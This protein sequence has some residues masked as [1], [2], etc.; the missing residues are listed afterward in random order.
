M[1]GIV[2]LASY[3]KS[4]N[5]WFRAF[6][7]N[8]L[9][10]GE[11]PAK[12][13]ALGGGPI[14]SAR[15]PFDD[16][17]GYDSGELT[18]DETDRLRP[19][20][21]LHLA[22]RTPPEGGV[23]GARFCKVHDAYTFLPD[24]RPLFPP[25]ATRSA[26]HFVRNPLDVCVSSAHH[27]GHERYDRVVKDMGDPARC[28]AAADAAESNQLRQRLLTWSGHALSWADAPGIRVLTLRYEDMIAR[29]EETFGAAVRFVGLPDDAARVKKAIAFSRFEEL[30]KQEEAHGFYEKMAR[31]KVFFRRGETG[32]WRGALTPEQSAKLIADHAAAMRRFG[33]LDDQ[34]EPVF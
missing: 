22:Q 21:Y 5:T 8:F 14:A 29:P 11:E 28:L 26:L 6:L 7:T 31:A 25:E 12:I 18:F 16:A 20:V 1:N 19:E 10:D 4:G 30:K 9:R 32:A 27:S 2:W 24:G 13:N 15:G 33:Y 34:G 3:P 17:V 23:A